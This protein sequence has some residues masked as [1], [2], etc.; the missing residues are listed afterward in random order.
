[1]AKQ[2]RVSVL[3]EAIDSLD[4]EAIKKK[5]EQIV[6]ATPKPRRY[7]HTWTEKLEMGRRI[8]KLRH[9]M[10]LS[11][12]NFALLFPVS[13]TLPSQWEY[14]SQYPLP[15]HVK[16]VERLEHEAGMNQASEQTPQAPS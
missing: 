13:P 3:Q 10:K 8:R 4:W 5:A 16:T 15:V 1:M 6:A 9:T 11:V 7:G 12:R 14:G 2:R